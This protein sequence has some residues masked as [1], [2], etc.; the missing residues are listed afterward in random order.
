MPFDAEPRPNFPASFDPVAFFAAPTV[1]HAVVRGRG[2][3]LLKRCRIDTVGE[4]SPEHDALHF[5][6]IYRFEDGVCD[7]LHWAVRRTQDGLEAREVSV[8]GPLRSELSGAE[9]RVRFRRRANPPAAGPVLLYDVRFNL[10]AEDLLVKAVRLS[11]LGVPV[12]TLTG[13]HRRVG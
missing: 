11:L 4:E 5:D 7:R 8:V 9:W 6:E 12:A 1:G 3:R 10:V 2:G 13:H